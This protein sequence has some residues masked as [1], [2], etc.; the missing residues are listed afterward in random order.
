[1]AGKKRKKA[2]R[3]P[4]K[5]EAPPEPPKPPKKMGRPTA[6]TAELARELVELRRTT[7][8]FD[9]Q[10][11]LKC[12]IA[13]STLRGWVSMGL[14]EDAKEPFLSFAKEYSDA[15]IDVEDRALKNI[16]E[17]HEEWKADAWFLERFRP[18]RYALERVPQGGPRE[19]LDVQQLI[20]A[21]AERKRT[22]VELL[23]EPPPELVS[24]L[25]AC[26]AQ[27]LALLQEQEPEK[28]PEG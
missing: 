2:A 5:P 10:I 6:L 11:A 23:S 28:L 18:M 4:S 17:H 7:R 19:A 3:R 21:G 26:K 9:T 13:D 8:L 25:V 20:E 27:V 24:A 15:S 22:L 14:A 1:M 12:G 16:E